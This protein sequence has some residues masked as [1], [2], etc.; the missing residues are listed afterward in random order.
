MKKN[1]ITKYIDEYLKH[2]TIRN[3]SK[4]TVIER[5]WRL[6]KFKEFLD[7]KEISNIDDINK[8]IIISYQVHLFETINNKG[9]QN[10]AGHQNN[11]LSTVIQ[12]LKFLKERDFIV[13]NPACDIQYAKVPKKLPKGILTPTE[14]KKI[15]HAPDIETA[16]GYRDRTMLEILYSSGIRKDE[17]NRLSLNDVDYQDGYLRVIGKGQKDRIVPIG[18]IACRYLENYMKSVRHEFYKAEYTNYLFLSLKGNKL[19]KNVIWEM[20]KKYAKRAKIRKNVSPHTFRHTCATVMLKNKADINIIRK[21][22]GHES[23]N[24]T[25]I[26]TYLSITDLKEVHNR[27]HPRE[28]DKDS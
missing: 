21:L 4:N 17:L 8:E 9:K 6:E 22:L 16:I 18:R 23:L 13:S 19:S 25:Q 5:K 3:L 20:I 28:K 7:K 14:A 2:M 1:N 10:S 27:C 26:Y 24:T 12:L 15:I 11:M